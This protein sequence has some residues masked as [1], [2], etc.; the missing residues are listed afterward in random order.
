MTCNCFPCR[1]F[2]INYRSHALQQPNS[3]ILPSTF[4]HLLGG[5]KFLQIPQY[6]GP[7]SV[8]PAVS[9]G[10][11]VKGCLPSVLSIFPPGT[12]NPHTPFSKLIADGS[13][14][15][16]SDESDTPKLHT[17][18]LNPFGSFRFKFAFM[19]NTTALSSF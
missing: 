3:S 11:I 10:T 5:E 18:H 1:Q 15:R 8:Y 14:M 16:H 4:L 13:R 6:V 19:Y 7:C 9:H 2:I 17:P 12:N